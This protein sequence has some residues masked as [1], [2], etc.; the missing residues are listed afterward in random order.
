MTHEPN[1]IEYLYAQR[2]RRAAGLATYKNAFIQS[3]KYAEFLESTPKLGDY[4]P[5]NEDGEVM[6]KPGGL[7]EFRHDTGLEYDYWIVA[8]LEYQSA[9]D[10]ILWEGWEIGK[11]G[12]VVNEFGDSIGLV[13]DSKFVVDSDKTTYELLINSGVKLERI[14]RK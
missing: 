13:K 14:Q 12:W 3:Y 9:L 5:T 6:E 8:I 11:H 1:M 2:L 4:V 10:R 7:E